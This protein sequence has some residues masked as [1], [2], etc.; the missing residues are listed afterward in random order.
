MARREVKAPKWKG[1]PEESRE[2]LFSRVTYMIEHG[3]HGHYIAELCGISVGQVYTAAHKLGLSVRDYRDGR[4]SAAKRI[5]VAAP[6][7]RVIT[8]RG[9]RADRMAGLVKKYV[10][11]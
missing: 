8:R 2:Q 6:V 5:V 11:S 4:T 1:V 10:V 7:W 3:F 9:D